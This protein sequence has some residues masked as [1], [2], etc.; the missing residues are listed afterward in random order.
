MTRTIT[1]TTAF[2]KDY[3]RM[4][5]RGHVME[6]LISIIRFLAEGKNLEER[7]HDHSLRGNYEGH[8]ECHIEPDWLLIY[9]T[10]EEELG[11][12]RTGSHSDLFK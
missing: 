7:H 10:S 3:K 1:R 8:R 9:T 2:K 5:K 4:Q 11:L 6:R 12:A